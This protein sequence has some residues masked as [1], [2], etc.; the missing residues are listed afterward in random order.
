M[1]RRVQ[2]IHLKQNSTN[3]IKFVYQEIY[4]KETSQIFYSSVCACVYSL[5]NIP[6]CVR[7]YLTNTSLL[8]IPLCV[9][10]YVTNTSLLNIPLCVRVYVTNTSLLNIPL[11]VRVYV[12][13]SVEYSS[14]CACVCN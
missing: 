14:V 6:L 1:K 3:K 5:L 4:E 2:K 8:N 7:V 9:S 13:E 11:C 10:V 12:T